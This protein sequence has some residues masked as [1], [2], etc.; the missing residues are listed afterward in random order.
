VNYEVLF[1]CHNDSKLNLQHQTNDYD[2]AEHFFWA[3]VVKLKQA[4]DKIDV[5]T[6]QL[7]MAIINADGSRQYKYNFSKM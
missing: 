3:M 6:W 5:N 2:Q 4:H 7:T 1:L